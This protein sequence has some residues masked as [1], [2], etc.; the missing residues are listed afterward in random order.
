MAER[1]KVIDE[2]LI[3]KNLESGRNEP[4]E[5]N[6]D[7]LTKA[8]KAKGLEPEEAAALLQVEDPDLLR[9]IFHAAQEV[10]LRIY[11]SVWSSL[12]PFI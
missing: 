3:H 1:V 12:P 10:K 6:L 5:K 2:E 7:I 11:G 8:K 9:E 4:R